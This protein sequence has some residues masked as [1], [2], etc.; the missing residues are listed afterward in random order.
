MTD[1]SLPENVLSSLQTIM[2]KQEEILFFEEQ[3]AGRPVFGRVYVLTNQDLFAIDTDPKQQQTVHIPLTDIDA[4]QISV[5]SYPGMMPGSLAYQRAIKLHMK[6]GSIHT[7][8][9]PGPVLP[10]EGKLPAFSLGLGLGAGKKSTYSWKGDTQ[11][12]REQLPRKICAAA[13]IPFC[14][15]YHL[16]N[17][18]AN[19]VTFY[20]KSDLVF[21]QLCAACLKESSQLSID[22][23]IPGTSNDLRLP[24]LFGVHFD[25]PY[26]EACHARRFGIFKKRAVKL[27]FL[28]DI[29]A[30]LEFENLEYADRF[31]SLNSKV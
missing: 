19:Q 24:R 31:V 3:P 15:P 18:P 29:S 11:A 30:T 4:L 12:K 10:D 6:D 5:V 26:C 8:L 9:H 17:L 2:Q 13:K 20:I 21:P 16:P 7:L 27:K 1:Q 14:T 22:R 25:I 28:L 23:I